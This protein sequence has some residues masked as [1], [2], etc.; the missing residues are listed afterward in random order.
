MI[1]NFIV[2]AIIVALTGCAGSAS[3]KVVTTH[4][5]T[6]D[7]L[8]CKQI[9]VE[10]TKTQLIID[11]VNKDKDDISGAD[12]V[13]GLLWFPFNLIAKS[14]NYSDALEAAGSRINTLQDLKK[15]KNCVEVAYIEETKN[16]D[17]ISAKLKEINELYKQG[18]LTEQEYKDAKIKILDQ[19]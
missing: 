9:D 15:D 14:Q 6:D 2:V 4:E 5:A 18:I 13:D 16:T 1:R 10:L 17:G 7:S 11:D 12:V 8:S 3:H 19:L